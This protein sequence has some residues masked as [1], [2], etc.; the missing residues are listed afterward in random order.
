[1]DKFKLKSQFNESTTKVESQLDHMW[2]NVYGNECK[3]GVIGAY[4]LAF[5]KLIYIAFKLQ[6][7]LSMYNKKSSIFP[8]I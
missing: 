7:T 1:M 2:A 8:F 6:N 4:W 5:H 3:Y